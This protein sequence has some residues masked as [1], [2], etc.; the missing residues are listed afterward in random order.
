[1]KTIIIGAGS[2]LG[3]H[4]DGASLGPVQL[5]KDLNNFY[6]GESFSLVQDE[7]II[8]SRNLSDRRKNEYDID[9]FNTKLYNYILEKNKDEYFPITIGGDKSVSIASSLASAKKYENIGMIWISAN[10]DYNTFETTVTGNISGLS[11][12]AINGYKTH[13]LRYYHKDNVIQTAKTVV[14]GARNIDDWEK[15]NIKYSGLNVL[16]T[17]DIKEK[18]I[19]TVL[20]EA[21]KIALEK[22]NGVH[23]CF[24][25]D[26]IDPDIA[27]GVS[28]PKFDG[29]SEDDAMEINKIL[30]SHINDI[31]S[32]DLL[33]FNPLRDNNRKTEQI[34][35]NL[36]AQVI[37][38]VNKKGKS[39]TRKY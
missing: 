25:L 28:I 8:K 9:N 18:G 20:E 26:L 12:A 4:I 3:V 34:A 16:T 24:S 21:F 36:I 32:Y 7:N 38:A 19:A 27:P 30:L 10:T 6:K 5:M 29:I 1:M 35:L 23:I 31:T 11:L 37:N 13:E 33:D 17:N 14:V 15:D 22:T 39:F 2:D